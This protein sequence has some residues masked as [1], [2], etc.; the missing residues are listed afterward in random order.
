MQTNQP[1]EKSQPLKGTEK[2]GF[3]EVS[4]QTYKQKSRSYASE[5]VENVCGSKNSG[6]Q[7]ATSF[8][9]FQDSAPVLLEKYS[10]NEEM[11]YAEAISGMAAQSGKEQD[12]AESRA[13]IIKMEWENA[14]RNTNARA[15]ERREL[16]YNLA[17]AKED[18]GEEIN[19]LTKDE[20]MKK[21]EEKER[22][23]VVSSQLQEAKEF[24]QMFGVWLENV[25][26]TEEEQAIWKREE[27][28][29]R[30]K[31]EDKER[32]L[33]EM[34]EERL[35]VEELWAMLNDAQERGISE[36]RRKEL[37]DL[38]RKNEKLQEREEK[39]KDTSL[40]KRYEK[41]AVKRYRCNKLS[42]VTLFAD[43]LVEESGESVEAANEAQNCSYEFQKRDKTEK[44]TF[45]SSWSGDNRII[46][47][48]DYSLEDENMKK[49]F[50]TAQLTSENDEEDGKEKDYFLS[51]FNDNLS[52]KLVTVSSH[53]SFI[54]NHSALSQQLLLPS[55][56]SSSSS[57]DSPPF[58]FA[59][60][61][62]NSAKEHYH[63]LTSLL[64]LPSVQSTNSAHTKFCP[65]HSYPEQNI[66][67]LSS[68]Q[69][70]LPF[71]LTSFSSEA[72]QMVHFEPCA[73]L[74]AQ[75]PLVFD[76]DAFESSAVSVLPQFSLSS[77]PFAG[78]LNFNEEV[79]ELCEIPLPPENV[80]IHPSV[81]S[82]PLARQ[83]S[84]RF[85]RVVC[86]HPFAPYVVFGGS[87]YHRRK[88]QCVVQKKLKRLRKGRIIFWN[89][90]F[91]I[92][93]NPH[94]FGWFM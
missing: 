44:A 85:S 34:G 92:P 3:D 28:A 52:E 62:H 60:E 48:L 39:K 25:W 53:K 81:S 37:I 50:T 66:L 2:Y 76:E 69:S 9:R 73:L 11:S 6:C 40:K 75:H 19:W 21:R 4:Y 23:K 29:A 67:S 78:T 30:A 43:E 32:K 71:L 74:L 41:H 17:Q 13:T 80:F 82:L 79:V 18:A 93:K 10:K 31:A 89:I 59:M 12:I 42:A 77:L 5:I 88:C 57:I 63:S 70:S 51:T 20:H 54:N 27:E 55:S 65:S 61:A 26:L 64:C 45:T 72:Q 94:L 22:Q 24:F 87:K 35:T 68:Q 90:Q 7:Q 83:V 84:R 38:I 49:E 36:S 47:E 86:T 8:S 16:L 56:S 46:E 33:E 1:L 91:H 15:E 58:Q 14:M